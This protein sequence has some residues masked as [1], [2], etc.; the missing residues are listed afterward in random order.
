VGSGF[1]SMFIRRYQAP[2]NEAVKELHYAGVLQ[3]DPDASLQDIPFMDSDLDDIAGIYLNNRGDFIVGMESKEIVAM[4]AIRKVS[5]KRGEIKRIRVRQDCQRQ[6][7]GQTILLK[8][9]EI[10]A[11]LGYTELCL[12]TLTSNVPAQKLFEKCGFV[13]SHRG[14]RGPYDLIFYG[15]KLSKDKRG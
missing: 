12:D 5:A 4:G 2:D 7:Y 1:T 8:L 3:M 15:K 11:K 10:A 13:E 6:G 9:M 14:K